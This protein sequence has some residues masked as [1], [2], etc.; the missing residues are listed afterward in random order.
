MFQ[1]VVWQHMQGVIGP[2]ITTLLQKFTREP[3]SERI[4]KI[5]EDL[6]QLCHEF[7]AIFWPTLY[8]PLNISFE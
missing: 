4:F 3:S 8:D 7:G 2:I 1:N 5:G 6:T